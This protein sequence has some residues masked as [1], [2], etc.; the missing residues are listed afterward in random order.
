VRSLIASSRLK[1][2]DGLP[3][4]GVLLRELADFRV[5]ITAQANET[6]GAGSHGEHDDLVVAVALAVWDLRFGSDGV[7]R[8]ER[9]RSGRNGAP[10]DPSMIGARRSRG[11]SF[12]GLTRRDFFASGWTP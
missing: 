10:L 1:V 4:A 7:G 11:R 2:A 8:G 12:Q 6:F 9:L 3:E 5:S